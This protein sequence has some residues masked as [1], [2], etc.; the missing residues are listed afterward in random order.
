MKLKQ[1]AQKLAASIPSG[2][3]L[4]ALRDI[5]DVLTGGELD[6]IQLDLLCDSI[7]HIQN[8]DTTP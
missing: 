3:S 7:A 2:M 4:E 5:C 6:A 1:T 8:K